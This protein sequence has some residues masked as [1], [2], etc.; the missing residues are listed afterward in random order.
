VGGAGLT[1][2]FR[3]SHLTGLYSL[4]IQFLPALITTPTSILIP[5]FT[6]MFMFWHIFINKWGL[7]GNKGHN[8][9]KN[10][11]F[12]HCHP[13]FWENISQLYF[14]LPANIFQILFRDVIC[15]IIISSMCKPKNIPNKYNDDKLERLVATPI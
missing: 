1:P 2:R 8:K 15:S 9:H 5:Q 4:A 13:D 14:T 6:I 3:P 10:S 11:L 12:V 7:W